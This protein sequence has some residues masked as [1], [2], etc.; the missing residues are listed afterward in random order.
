MIEDRG[1]GVFD[2][3][4]GRG[5]GE[6]FA[7]ARGGDGMGPLW[8]RLRNDCPLVDHRLVNGWAR[9]AAGRPCDLAEQRL[10]GPAGGEV[11]AN[12]TGRGPDASGQLEQP[13]A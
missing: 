7:A 11:D 6:F 8:A 12:A 2:G 3:A 9:S 1:R 13:E 4:S 10:E 5:E